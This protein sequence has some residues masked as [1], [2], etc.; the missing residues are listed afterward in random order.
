MRPEYVISLS[1][2]QAKLETAG[3]KGASLA[4]LSRAG[5]PVP[6]GFHV[7]T[8]A[9]QQYVAENDLKPIIMGALEKVDLSQPATL[10]IASSTIR[11]KFVQG[12]IPA[13]ITDAISQAYEN[14]PGDHPVVAVRSSATAEDL[15]D[16]SFAGQQ[17][18]FLNIHG[19]PAV[20]DAVK[21]CWGSLW[22][23]RAIGYRMQHGID[24]NSVSLAVVVQLLVHA[25]AAGILFT[26]NPVT[27]QR[28]QAMITAAWGLGEAIVG[29]MVTPDTLVMDKVTGRVLGRETADKQVMT[30]LL[31]SSTAEH[32]VSETMRRTPVLSDGQ[33]AELMQLGAQIEQ[34]YNMPMDIEWTLAEGKFAI[35]Q[36][37]PITALPE[38]EA[39][40]P[41]EWERPDPKVTYSRGSI[42]EFLP[43]PL[44]PLFK[45]LGLGAI[46]EGTRRLFSNLTGDTKAWQDLKVVTINEYAYMTMMV[47]N[48]QKW[49]M[50]TKMLPMTRSAFAQGEQAWREGVRPRIIEAVKYWKERPTSELAPTE[51]LA[52][53]H[54]LM[55]ATVHY[56]TILQSGILAAAMMCD[57]MF[58]KI[59]DR[60]IRREGDPEAVTFLVGFDSIPIQAEKALFDLAEWARSRPALAAYLQ[61]IPASDLA[62][63]FTPFPELARGQEVGAELLPDWSEFADRFLDYLQTYGHA[64]Y[65]LDFSDPIPADDPAP[66]LETCKMY[67]AGRGS[68]PYLRQQ[69]TSERREQATQALLKRLKGLR[70]KVFL[71]LMGWA[72]KWGPLRED[73]IAD[74]GLGYPLIR[75]MLRELGRRFVQAGAIAQSEDIFWME[76]EE[77]EHA[78]FALERGNAL[79]DLTTAVLQRKATWRAARRVTPPAFLP[80]D[81]KLAKLVP[82][83]EQQT[84][85]TLK[86]F[87]AS[88]GRVSAPARVLHGPE[89][90]NQMKTGDVLVAAITTP[91]WTPLFAMASAVVTDIGGLL[92]HGSIVA[93]EYG[94]PAVL[95]TG[96]AT[97]RI[98]SGQTITVDGTKG[99]VI[100]NE[101]GRESADGIVIEWIPPN[102]KGVYMRGSAVD[103]MPD[104]LSPLFASMGI[105]A[106]ISGVN[107]NVKHLTRSEPVLPEDYFTTI[108]N[109]AYGNAGFTPRAWWWIISRLLP[110]YPRL[111]RTM[112]PFWR[113]E[114]RPQ[115]RTAIALRQDKNIDQLRAAELWQEAQ[116]VLDVT[117]NYLG[118]LMFATM[119][120]SAGSEGLLTRVYDRLVK[121]END[122]PATTLLMG[123]NSIPVQAEKSLYDLAIWCREHP[124][125]SAYFLSTPSEQL[126]VQLKAEEPPDSIRAGD[127][128]V[129]HERFEQHLKQYGHLIYELDF[130]KPLPLDDPAP[131]LETCKMYLRGEGTN[132]HDRQRLSEEKRKQTAQTMLGRLKGFRLWAFRKALNWAQSMAEV[133]EDAL[134]DIGLGYP[135]LRQILRELGRCFVNAGAIQQP[136]DIFWLERE[137]IETGVHKLEQGRSF[138]SLAESVEQRKAFWRAAKRATPPPVLPPKEKIMGIKADLFTAASESSQ[139][140]DVLKGVATSV[141]K[142]TAPACVL[143]GPEDFNLMEPGAVLVAGTTTPAWTPLFAMASAVV[144]DIGGPLSHGSIVAREYN[145]PAVMGTGIATRRIRSGQVITVDGTAGMVTLSSDGS[146]N[147]AHAA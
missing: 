109:Y 127:W 139:T 114:A 119:G 8:A 128:Q 13:D 7:V 10:E 71:K 95:G 24:Q 76:Q 47:T 133:R 51:I 122:P 70:R 113:D 26:A 6:D 83:S 120:A 61:E 144:T 37:R 110:A 78:A 54:Q 88:A 85:E 126:V 97:R 75:Q 33:A 77:V 118:M 41:T 35:V 65:D 101:P 59:Y 66:L 81:S 89:D 74:M 96:V 3:G 108:N 32:P 18:T 107:Q 91:A 132:P 56:Y 115:F 79:T 38:L 16:L 60:L 137:E 25:E 112:V 30:V 27:G 84:G 123:Y 1:D 15:P 4:R 136:E 104:P 94:I 80:V 92:S 36:A 31:E 102:P 68:N 140:G 90:F 147:G 20:L 146:G 57:T 40:V 106:L 73:A 138:D 124:E 29:G 44:S 48:R 34:L 23:A 17:E 143:H 19:I 98:H 141:G 9:Y 21:R 117:M 52:G 49:L 135:L 53:V 99:E 12:Q 11:D 28:E 121:R 55:D 39:P 129:L 42:I 14:M 103:L 87:G 58:A 5:L 62:A 86:G 50:A 43:D 111:F 131:M 142:V 2:S 145:I 130:A 105:P 116:E 72:Q 82:W 134:A 69:T 100:L 46:D 67:L 125:L 45:T 22:T 64:V 63:H 93:R